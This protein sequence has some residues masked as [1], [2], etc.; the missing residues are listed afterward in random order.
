MA[1]ASGCGIGLA[2]MKILHATDDDDDDDDG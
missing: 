1:L 2:I